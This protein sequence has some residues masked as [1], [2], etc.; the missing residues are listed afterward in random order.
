VKIQDGEVT[1]DTIRLEQSA[2][3]FA[4]KP[5][6][7]RF[8]AVGDHLGQLAADFVASRAKP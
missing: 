2:H 5:V 7:L 8:A 1:S 4:T 6:E 3:G